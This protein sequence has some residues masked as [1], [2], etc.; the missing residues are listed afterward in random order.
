MKKKLS[1]Y[2]YWETE[3]S[4]DEES[5]YWMMFDTLEDAVSSGGDGIQVYR[6]DATSLGK[7]RR[8]VELEKVKKKKR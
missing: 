7:Y 1:Q 6:L 3:T 8:R 2:G 4:G 5:G